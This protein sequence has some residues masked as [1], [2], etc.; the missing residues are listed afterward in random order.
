[1]VDALQPHTYDY[2]TLQDMLYILFEPVPGA[3]FYEDVSDRPGVMRRYN[4]GDER[5]VGITVHD[6]QKRLP[7]GIP[8]DKAIRQLVQTLVK[9]LA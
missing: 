8:Q 9:Q 6:V 2:D 3:T 4:L 5:L 7:S 1:V